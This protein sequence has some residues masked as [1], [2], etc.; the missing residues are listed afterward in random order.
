MENSDKKELPI[1]NT[2]TVSKEEN[3]TEIPA[4]KK[5]QEAHVESTIG[6]YLD[7][8]THKPNLSDNHVMECSMHQF[9]SKQLTNKTNTID[10]KDDYLSP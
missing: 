10:S 1:E 3:R 9:R 4:H 7:D 2:I 8:T 6:I 5:E